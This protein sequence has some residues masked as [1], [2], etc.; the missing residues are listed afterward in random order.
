MAQIFHRSANTLAK[1]SIFGSVFLIG[2]LGA[3]AMKLDRSPINTKQGIVIHQPVP[4]SHE[5]H[6]RGPGHRLPLLPHHRRDAAFAG[7]PTARP[8]YNCHSQI[9]TNAEMLEPVRDGYKNDA[10]QVDAG[11]RPARLRVLQPLDPRR[12]GRRL[13]HLPRRGRPDAADLSGADAADAVVP[14]LPPR[15]ARFIRPKEEVF[16][17]TWTPA[18]AEEDPGGDRRAVGEGVR[19]SRSA[20]AHQLLDLPPLRSESWHDG[21]HRGHRTPRQVLSRP[22][23]EHRLRRLRPV[24]PSELDLDAVRAQ[25]AGARGPQFWRSLEELADDAAIPRHGAPGVPAPGVGLSGPDRRGRDRRAAIPQAA[26]RVAGAGRP[27]RL[28]PP[29]AR[30]DR[31][32]R[33]AAGRHRPRQA[34]VLRHRDDRSAATPGRAGREP[35]GPADQDRGQ[36]RPPCEPRRRPTPSPR[37]RPGLYDP[38]RSQTVTDRGERS[39]LGGVP[40]SRRSRR[41]TPSGSRGRSRHAHADRNGQLADPG[42]AARGVLD[43]ASRRRRWHQYEPIG[44]DA[45]RPG[46]TL[47]FGAG[48]RRAL[49]PS[50]GRRRPVARRRLP[51]RRARRSLRYARQFADRPAGAERR[52]RR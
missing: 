31:A 34:A 11:P 39:D 12:Q 14:R 4:F 40:R 51:R 22:A 2:I 29:A 3:L 37:R 42:G 41:S 17:M 18:S 26:R 7:I 50:Q 32:V 24:E 27:D 45:A 10:D 13:R 49:R 16:N 20:D 36:P 38:D 23:E 9:W 19:H 15:P 52:R 47:A 6:V 35:H 48:R 5:H 30:A 25:L 21:A 46:A 44:R 33:Q 43:A 28:H 8:A 1:V